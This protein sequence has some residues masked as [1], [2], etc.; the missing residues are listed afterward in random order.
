LR[1]EIETFQEEAAQLRQEPEA[2]AGQLE[3]LSWEPANRLP[4]WYNARGV[5]RAHPIERS[6]GWAGS[7]A[8]SAGSR[9]SLPDP[10]R[11][12]QPVKEFGS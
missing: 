11:L 2:L 9:Q 10:G 12:A 6:T 3:A 7:H 8:S 4:N 1:P 5:Q